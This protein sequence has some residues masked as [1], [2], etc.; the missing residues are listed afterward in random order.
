MIPPEHG[1]CNQ[2]CK[3]MD[4][5]KARSHGALGDSDGRAPHGTGLQTITSCAMQ[6][7]MGIDVEGTW[8]MVI[9]SGAPDLQKNG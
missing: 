3:G 1:D 8:G 6:S 9:R 7:A 2:A 5:M 4:E